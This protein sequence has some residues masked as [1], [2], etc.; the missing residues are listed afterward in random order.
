M[1]FKI[2]LVRDRPASVTDFVMTSLDY[3]K[4]D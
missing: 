4:V 1:G 2:P 3:K